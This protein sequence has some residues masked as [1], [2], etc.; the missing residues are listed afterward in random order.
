[1]VKFW[2]KVESNSFHLKLLW[3]LFGQVFENLG[4]F[5][6]QHLVTL[7]GRLVGRLAGR[8]IGSSMRRN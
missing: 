2:A 1:M 6:I 5:L 4:Y 7:V 3:L 8:Q